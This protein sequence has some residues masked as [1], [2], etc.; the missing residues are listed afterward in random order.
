MVGEGYG[1]VREGSPQQP[2]DVDL[3]QRVAVQDVAAFT[4]LYERYADT[5]YALAAHMLGAAD[6]EEV[7]QEVFLQL[8]RSADQFD[9]ARGS[10][11]SWFMTI[12]RNRAIDALKHRGR[13]QQKRAAIAVEQA[14]MNAADPTEDLLNTV[15][16]QDQQPALLRS[17][18][19]LPEEQ[20][21]AIILAYFG[22]YSQ[23]AIAR[24]LEWPLGTVKKRI[25]LGL[26]KLRQALLPDEVR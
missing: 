1:V 23:S 2:S 17:L 14:L 20:R 22:G 8:W 4:L 16:V 12:A 5:V 15:W 9:A 7:T 26:Q 6:A 18:Q 24:L 10:F 25:R 13:D 19:D 21:R 11:K 3:A